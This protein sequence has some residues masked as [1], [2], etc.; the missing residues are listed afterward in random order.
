MGNDRRMELTVQ[1]LNV[2]TILRWLL[3]LFQGMEGSRLI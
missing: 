1:V 2:N 3:Y